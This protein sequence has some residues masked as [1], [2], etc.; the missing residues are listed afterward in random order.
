MENEKKRLHA[1]SVSDLFPFHCVPFNLQVLIN[2]WEYPSLCKT[3]EKRYDEGKACHSN[4][5][6]ERMVKGVSIC[7]KYALKLIRGYDLTK[8]C[9]TACDDHRGIHSSC[10]LWYLLHQS[11][12]KHV[13]C[14]RNCYGTT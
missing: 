2:I 6:D 7:N 3:Y 10:V 1:T 13:L 8:G 5:E 14:N 9:C 12:R 4:G 11:V